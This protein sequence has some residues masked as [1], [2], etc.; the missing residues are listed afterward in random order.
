V[1]AV[2]LES[3]ACSSTRDD[4]PWEKSLGSTQWNYVDDDDDDV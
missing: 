4:D 2:D 3:V 1:F